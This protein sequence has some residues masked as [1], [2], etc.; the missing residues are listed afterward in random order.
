MVDVKTNAS[1]RKPAG[2]WRPAL[3]FAAGAAAITAIAI[4]LLSLDASFVQDRNPTTDNAYVG[5]D[6][7]AIS[8]RV[9]G[10][11]RRLPVTDNQRVAAGDLIAELDDDDYRADRDQARANLEAAQARL[12]AAEAQQRE[13]QA[14]IAQIRTNEQSSI[15]NTARTSP[16]L[17]RQ[18]ILVHTDAGVRRALDQA[19]SDQKRSLANIAA[20]HAQLQVRERQADILEAQR[21]EDIAAVAARQADLALAELN[22]D[23]TR[24]K[25]PIDGTLDLRRVRV[26]DLLS[27]GTE[28]VGVTPLDTVWVDA[29]MLERQIPNIR[30]GQRASLKLDAFPREKLEGR[31]VALSP[32]TGGRLGAIPPDNTTGNFPKVPARVPVRIA[33]VWDASR[34][35]GLARPGMS[36]TAQIFTTGTSDPAGR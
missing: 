12:T 3:V 22:L 21:L 27:P 10:Y 4:L 32:L 26:G 25:A 30:V 29:N 36:V 2:R 17:A 33:I 1:A 16:E 18:E 6:V 8:A 34:L 14:Q 24:I 15:A 20:A 23:W 35:R 28:L 9:A 19:A 13:L 7:T 31:V 5:G 11:V